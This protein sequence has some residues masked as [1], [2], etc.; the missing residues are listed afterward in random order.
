MASYEQAGAADGADPS[1]DRTLAAGR[2]PPVR[3]AAAPRRAEAAMPPTHASHTFGAADGY[4]PL[5]A[6]YDEWAALAVW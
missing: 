6:V 3:R 2:P 5:S 4:V 1:D